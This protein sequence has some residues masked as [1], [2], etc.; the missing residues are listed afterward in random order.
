MQ[1][2]P[3]NSMFYNLA[4]NDMLRQIAERYALEEL[5]YNER[6]VMEAYLAK[7]LERGSE[8]HNRPSFAELEHLDLNLELLEGVAV[9]YL[10]EN[11][12]DSEG[13]FNVRDDD[14]V[15]VDYHGRRLSF[16]VFRIL[17][18][19]GLKYL[20]L[21]EPGSHRYRFEPV[22]LHRL[23]VER[24]N[25]RSFLAMQRTAAFSPILTARPA[26]SEPPR[27]APVEATE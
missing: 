15:T 6:T 21:R 19:S 1:Y 22:W 13:F 4:G 27:P 20:D 5:P 9:K 7:W 23:L 11:R 3:V 17:D 16:P 12:V 25:D 8:T 2:P 14:A 24:H 10:L 26:D 18:R